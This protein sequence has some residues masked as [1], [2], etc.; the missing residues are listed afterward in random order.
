MKITKVEVLDNSKGPFF[1]GKHHLVFIKIYT[2]EGIYGVGEPVVYGL[3]VPAVV[4]YLKELSS[5][6]I[7]EDP[8]NTEKIWNRFHN[9][10]EAVG[11]PLTV[12]AISAIDIALWDIKGK[13][14][15]VP[16]YKLLGGKVRDKV[17]VYLSHIEFGYPDTDNP[18]FTP[19]E[20]E[21]V[22]RKARDDGYRIVKASFIK[23]DAKGNFNRI[24]RYNPMSPAFIE[25]IRER[26]DA[27]QRGLGPDGEIIIENNAMTGTEDAVRILKAAEYCNISFYEEPTGPEFVSQMKYVADRTAFPVATGERVPTRQGLRPFLEAGAVRIWMPDVCNAGGITEFKKIADFAE[28][29]GV[30]IS[31]HTCGGPINQAASIHL[32]AVINNFHSHEHHVHTINKHNF[33]YG[34]YKY[35]A[36][37][38]FLDVPELPGLGQ[39]IA[40]EYLSEFDIYTIEGDRK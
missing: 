37:G 7:G 18:P 24:N 30:S 10:W 19:K 5:L 8:F 35:D 11:G 1:V 25:L 4:E 15:G 22:A 16:V 17:P 33:K 3:G 29:Y 13:A 20:F 21:Q 23:H 38:G 9:G 26:L 36:K 34:K 6:I 31:S 12:S 32:G 28:V 27:V 2:D 14:L 39:D 40:E